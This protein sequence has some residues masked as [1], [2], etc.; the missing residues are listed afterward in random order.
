M[1]RKN[2]TNFWILI[3]EIKNWREKNCWILIGDFL[4]EVE[5]GQRKKPKCNIGG[6]AEAADK[7]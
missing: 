1:A 3:G 5:W 7:D 6:V 2:M 4:I